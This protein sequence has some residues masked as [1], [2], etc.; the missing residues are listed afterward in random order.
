M[1]SN[2]AFTN[3]GATPQIGPSSLSSLNAGSTSA[4]KA[5]ASFGN[6]Y[7]ASIPKAPTAPTNQSVTSHS[8]TSPDGSVVTQKYA[9]ISGVLPNNA[10]SGTQSSTP[11]TNQQGGLL[12]SVLSQGSKNASA[13]ATGAQA[14]Y[15][16]P[17]SGTIPGALSTAP[18]G[19]TGT[20]PAGSSPVTTSSTSGAQSTPASG[21]VTL[22]N[23]TVVNP[24]TG[25]VVS[26]GAGVT[27]PSQV[28]NSSSSTPPV[29]TSQNSTNTAP[30]TTTPPTTT[31]PTSNSGIINSLVAGGSA[32]GAA[33]TAAENAY[34]QD[35]KNYQTIQNQE[36]QSLADNS[37]APEPIQEQQGEG[38]ILQT[39]YASELAAAGGLVSGASN[40]LSAA[41]TQQSTQQ[42]GLINAGTL[43]Q[44][45]T[46]GVGGVPVYTSTGAPV[47]NGVGGTSSSTTGS[48]ASSNPL[49]G[50]NSTGN[51]LVDTSVENALQ[52][53]QNGSSTTDAMLSIAGG[54]V[55]QNAFIKAMQQYDPSWSITSSNA[56]AAQNMAQGQK[57]QG[58]ATDLNTSLGQLSGL[59][60]SVTSLI[61]G[62]GL[63]QNGSPTINGFINQYAGQTDQPAQVASLKAAMADVS[64]YVSS[65]LGAGGDLTATAVTDYTKSFDP[66]NFT[67]PELTTFLTNLSNYG[68]IRLQGFQQSETG[69][70]GGASGYTGATATPSPTAAVGQ[71][72]PDS[73]GIGNSPTGQALAGAA[74]SALGG[75]EGAITGL[76]QHLLQ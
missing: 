26:Q 36:A 18:S 12:N 33:Y 4:S 27:N 6:P 50:S 14:P 16:A 11:V 75:I 53:I 44:Q 47:G 51:A 38:Q 68:Q 28:I 65:I 5:L 25:A 9:P 31:P 10:V 64:S 35:L 48:S 2:N 17:V 23:G 69:S 57:F 63:N 49:L 3:S 59:T 37:S 22:A 32:P 60:P 62:A 20:I 39:Q 8:V 71:V 19:L 21:N 55:G 7:Q 70:Y 1:P 66:G 15:V 54:T 52:Q 76:A 61:N 72:N 41:N 74:L 73:F 40:A 56:I 67:A 24:T 34:Q 46:T 13:G 58:Q 43:G 30:V 29:T 42:S 45:T